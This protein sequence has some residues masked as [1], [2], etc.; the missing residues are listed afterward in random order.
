M[1]A[2]PQALVGALYADAFRQ[3]GHA[4]LWSKK[5]VRHPTTEHA[6]IIARSLRIE[7]GREAYALAREIEEAC[8]A[9]D[10]AAA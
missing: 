9:A 6:R 8:D 3:F 1:S 2:E 5:P 4:C 7:G 10:L